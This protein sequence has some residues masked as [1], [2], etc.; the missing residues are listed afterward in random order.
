[1]QDQ[2]APIPGIALPAPVNDQWDYLLS[3][4][5]N[6]MLH[7]VL[8][9]DGR[10][11]EEKLPVAMRAVMD[12]E[13]VLCSRFVESEKPSWEAL[14]PLPPE[15]FFSRVS[16]PDPGGVLPGVLVRQ[17]DARR[18][19]PVHLTLIRGEMDT[20]VLSVNHTASD[21]Y[22]VRYA[23]FL[24]A[25]AYREGVLPAG[26]LS[27]CR[28]ERDRSFSPLLLDLPEAVVNAA[29]EACG[30]Q[31]A[32][33]GI[34]CG[35]GPCRRPSYEFRTIDRD[36]F[37]DIRSCSRACG[38]TINDL[39]LA[40]FFVAVSR[41]IPHEEDGLYPVLTSVDLRRLVPS[42]RTAPVANLSVAFEVHLSANLS[43]SFPLLAK[44]VH[45]VMER[46][47]RL[48][49][50]IG[51]AVR[52]E[53]LFGAAGF[54]AVR[55]YLE[56]ERRKSETM[57]YPKNPFFSNTGIIPQE[58]GDFGGVR[59]VHAFMVPPVDYPPGF[60]VA[61]STFQERLTLASGFCRDCLSENTVRRVL[62]CMEESLENFA[63]RP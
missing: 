63:R 58:C 46:K 47:K 45:G 53:E 61:A 26:L 19:P 38:M 9:L 35:K 39:L 22:G 5:W 40:S 13:P 42:A 37:R 29:K 14:P 52:L 30:D 28:H 43:R 57:G 54:H 41:E 48:R 49:A 25:Q 51:A 36:L 12:A 2:I 17:L 24:L 1:M 56:E 33:W 20:L 44:E 32:V 59:A 34:P 8:C 18:G 62:S 7:L 23:A 55:K 60:S 6:Q 21:A 16:D 27:P 50:G 31:A 10:L 11:D 3:T 15:S 4:I